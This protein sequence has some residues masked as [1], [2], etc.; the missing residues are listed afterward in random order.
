VALVFGAYGDAC[1]VQYVH[2]YAQRARVC[3][4]GGGPGDVHV[5]HRLFAYGDRVCSKCFDVQ[6]VINRCVLGTLDGSFT[7]CAHR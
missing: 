7:L 3:P 2:A 4:S 1:L 5:L 6:C